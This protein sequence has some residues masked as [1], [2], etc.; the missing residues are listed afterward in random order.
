MTAYQYQATSNSGESVT[1]VID[2]ASE[3]DVVTEL[4]EQGLWATNVEEQARGSSSQNANSSRNIRISKKNVE[5]FTRELADLLHAGVSLAKALNIICRETSNA[6]AKRLFQNIFDD[7]SDGCSLAEALSKSP[8][9]FPLI[10]IAMIQAG[11]TGGFL[12]VVL[13]QIS[14]MRTRERDLVSRIQ[15]ALIY[16][17]V[18]AFVASGVMIF[19]LTYFIPKFSLIFSDLGG[20]LPILTQ[21]I[22]GAS[23][24]L[25]NYGIYLFILFIIL[26]AMLHRL[27]N[28]DQGK[29]TIEKLILRIPGFGTV[30][31]RFALIRFTSLLGTLLKTGVPLITSLNVAKASIGNQ[32][33]TDAVDKAI[34]DVK[35]GTALSFSFK[36]CAT[37]FPKSVIEMIAVAEESGRLDKELLRISQ[38]Y[39]KDLDIKLRTLVSLFEPVMLFVLAAM[40]GTIVIGML[41]P[42]FEL[43][44][45]IQ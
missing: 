31:A 12:D 45:L 4:S 30:I 22:V 40:V 41:L 3:A 26:I 35:Q 39:E 10:F 20:E 23:T 33:L 8:K 14:D 29:Y 36:K 42:V 19:L 21:I 43:Q 37:L 27:K 1:G 13:N 16:P 25:L 6:S 2:A 32:V 44:D 11:E 7:V 5:S 34:D 18:L 38:S 28:T 24:L 15:S 9:T 17:V